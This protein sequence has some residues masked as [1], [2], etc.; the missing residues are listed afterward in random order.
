MG[1]RRVAAVAAA[2][3][4]DAIQRWQLNSGGADRGLRGGRWSYTGERIVRFRFRRARFARDV[5]VS[6]SATWRL[7]D[8]AVRARLRL[9]GRGRLRAR[10]STQRPLA[11]AALD[12]RLGGRKLRATMLA[13]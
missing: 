10:W 3:V 2:T 5:P 7:S 4:A 9:P 12:G 1:A 13:P 8:G 6:G 11:V